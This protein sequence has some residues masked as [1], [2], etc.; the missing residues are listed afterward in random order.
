MERSH[1]GFTLIELMVVIA[2]IAILTAIITANFSKARANSRDVK[3]IYDLSQIQLA[4][5]LFFDRCNAYPQPGSNNTLP[6]T[7]A[8]VATCPGGITLAT[9]I[10]PIP[11]PP[12]S[13]EVYDYAVNNSTTAT[14]YILRSKIESTNSV[15]NDDVDGT[16]YTLDCSDSPTFYYCVQPKL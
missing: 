4:L 1:K 16:V 12:N 13:G 8:T 2:I 15:L 10:S 5:E 3:R 7:T 11:T 14:D 6:A 9:F